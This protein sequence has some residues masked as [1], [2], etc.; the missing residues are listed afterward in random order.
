[1][2][3]GLWGCATSLAET[4]QRTSGA[5]RRPTH[6]LAHRCGCMDGRGT[7]HNVDRLRFVRL[8]AAEDVAALAELLAAIDPTYFHPHPFTREEAERRALY[9]G[10]DVYAV[11]EDG[12]RLVAYGMLRGWDEGY[13]V[14]A[15]GI[16]VRRHSGGR[17]F[18]RA[19]MIWLQEEARRRGA[20]RIRLRVHPDNGPAR[21]L[22]ESLGYRYEGEERG[23]L[24][25]ILEL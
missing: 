11:L 17:G 18:G 24:L 6:L 10:K 12:G 8:V 23:E 21:A 5:R 7:L 15:L 22:Y 9:Q 2:N 13:A 1:M 25:M 20:S 14:P 3:T 4:R 19:M 16:G